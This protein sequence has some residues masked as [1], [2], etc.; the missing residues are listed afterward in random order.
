[1]TQYVAS[2]P[3]RYQ[4]SCTLREVLQAIRIVKFFGWQDSFLARLDE[5]RNIELRFLRQRLAVQVVWVRAHRISIL[6]LMYD[7]DHRVSVRVHL[8]CLCHILVS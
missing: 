8:G 5:R 1:M 3:K 4:N 2:G 6:V 7:T